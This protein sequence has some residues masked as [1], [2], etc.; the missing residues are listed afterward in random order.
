MIV[1]EAG[2]RVQGG[3]QQPVLL[4]HHEF[5]LDLTECHLLVISR[6]GQNENWSK[7]QVGAVSLPF[8]DPSVPLGCLAS[9]WMCVREETCKYALLLAGHC[10]GLWP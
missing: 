8:T 3:R 7:E 2:R 6:E 9:L 5:G 1:V 10:S 4:C